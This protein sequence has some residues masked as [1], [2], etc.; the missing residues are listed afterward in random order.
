M[1]SMEQLKAYQFVEKAIWSC[2]TIKQLGSAYNLVCN[3][4]K[5]FGRSETLHRLRKLRIKR[6]RD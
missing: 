3:Y 1:S 5:K 2:T 4:E 6:M